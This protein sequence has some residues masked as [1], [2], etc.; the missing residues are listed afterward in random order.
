MTDYTYTDMVNAVQVL[1]PDVIDAEDFLDN[2]T[3]SQLTF[4]T[5]FLDAKFDNLTVLCYTV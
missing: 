4:I 2:A 5:N 1:Y 3:D